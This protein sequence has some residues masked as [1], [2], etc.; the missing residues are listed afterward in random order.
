MSF[1]IGYF[2]IRRQGHVL[3][4]SPHVQYHVGGDDRL[5]LT[6]FCPAILIANC[7]PCDDM[8]EV[9]QQLQKSTGGDDNVIELSDS[10]VQN[11]VD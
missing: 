9:K 4:H 1:V 11:M 3:R 2:N 6:V 5:D 7:P 10:R 8:P